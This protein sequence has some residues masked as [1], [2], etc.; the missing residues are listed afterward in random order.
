MP[1]AFDVAEGDKFVSIRVDS[2]LQKNSGFLSTS[3]RKPLFFMFFLLAVQSRKA[4]GGVAGKCQDPVLSI[5][6]SRQHQGL[7]T[8][9]NR[10]KCILCF[11]FMLSLAFSV[12]FLLKEK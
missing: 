7:G 11:C 1:L 2:W 5:C 3:V 10:Q 6:L 4:D 12:T 9:L 8:S